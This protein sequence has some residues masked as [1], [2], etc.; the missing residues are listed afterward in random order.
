[1]ANFYGAFADLLL[2]DK[3]INNFHSKIFGKRKM[4]PA[5]FSN[6]IY[7]SIQYIELFVENNKNYPNHPLYLTRE[8]WKERI[9]FLHSRYSSSLRKMLLENETVTTIYQRYL[10]NKILLNIIFPNKELLSIA[11]FGCG[12]NY[13][14]PGLS[15]GIPFNKFVDNTPEFLATKFKKK[16]ISLGDCLAVDKSDPI[17][18]SRWRE[19]CS[20]YPQE[21]K[22][23]KSVLKL[24][25]FEKRISKAK[26]VRFLKGDLLKLHVNHQGGTLPYKYF[27]AVTLNTILYQMNAP[28]R[29]K[30]LK[31]ARHCLK[32]G[33]VII[34]QDFA[35]KDKNPQKLDFDV[36]WFGKPGMYGTFIASKSTQWKFEHVLRW[37]NGR[38]NSVTAGPDFNFL[39]KP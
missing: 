32:E 39:L 33:G 14:L 4:Q 29:A 9:V 28:E 22:G 16:K 15:L 11:D 12:G 6:L 36:N 8:G 38:C 20:F 25:K 30:V 7:R 18:V 17:E 27:D 19:A 3:S 31:S 23:H 13:G 10:G 26:N 1:M 2:S 35:K 37:G 24:R 21:L 34:V 5:H